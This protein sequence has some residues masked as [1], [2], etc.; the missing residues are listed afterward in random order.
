ME[1]LAFTLGLV[2]RIALPVALLLLVS[3]RIQSWDARYR[4][5]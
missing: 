1:M 5:I 4:A 2:V 3:G